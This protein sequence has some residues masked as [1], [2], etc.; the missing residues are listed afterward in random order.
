MQHKIVVKDAI[1]HSDTLPPDSENTA[2]PG[3]EGGKDEAKRVEGQ[4]WWGEYEEIY[5]VV[6]G[7]KMRVPAYK[8][9][10]Y[11]AWAASPLDGRWPERADDLAKELGLRSARSFR[12]WRDGDHDPKGLIVAEIAARQAGPLM[13]HRRDLYDALIASATQPNEKGHN[14]RKLAFEMLGD[15]KAK[16]T[17]NVNVGISANV[18]ATIERIYGEPSGTDDSD[19]GGGGDAEGA[20]D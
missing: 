13:R 11:I 1:A 7:W 3:A 14:D 20:I 9:A 18:E 4:P 10:A 12:Q 5:E 17:A 6:K 19:G 16:P 2:V 8:V 15:Y